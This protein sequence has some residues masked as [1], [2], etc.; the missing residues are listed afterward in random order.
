MTDFIIPGILAVVALFGVFL[1]IAIVNLRRVVPTNMVHIVQSSKNTTSF[2]KGKEAG[3]TYYQW[4]AWLPVFGVVVSEFPESVFDISLKDYDAYDIGRLPFMVDIVAFFRIEESATAA[5]RVSSFEELR[6]QLKSVLQGAV[7]T[8][9][10]TNKLEEIMQDRSKLGSEFTTEVNHQ[11][12]EW[13]VTTVKSIE[14]MD[15]RDAGGSKVIANMMAKEQSR[16][17]MES[18]ITVAENIR[19]AELKEIDANRTIEVQKQDAAQQIGIRTATKE[20]EVG[21]ADEQARQEI[22]TQARTTSERE[23]EVK[24]VVEVK[25]ADI[26]KDVAIVKAEQDRQVTVVNSEADKRK[27]V[28]AA[29]AQRERTEVIAQG[30][31]A[32]A[33]NNAEGIKATGEATAKAEEL[34]LMAPVTAQ[35]TLAKEIG[36]NDNY[37]KYLVTVEQIKASQ[38]VG[39]EMAQAIKAAD[40]K[41]ISNSGTMQGGV[42]SIADI[43]SPNGGTAIS[44]LL[45]GLAQTPEGKALVGRF[46]DSQKTSPEPKAISA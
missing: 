22:L 44:G 33:K 19:E 30:D 4:P 46:T 21:I 27:V 10:S 24:K 29:E 7:R 14:F 40:I 28:I 34:I 38:T 35:I 36:D 39:V 3:N 42:A 13:G 2:G 18:R 6:E 1:V 11:L 20:K 8:I 37:Q 16:I 5:Q 43:F 41:V 32:A 12:Q 17:E 23:M 26:A 45:T 25:T 31:L 15:I 9:L